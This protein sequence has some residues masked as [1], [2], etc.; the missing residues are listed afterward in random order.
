MP[1]RS[2]QPGDEHAQ[3]RI[4]NTVAGC[5]PAFKPSTAD[6]IARRYQPGD[7]DGASRY[8][9][10]EDGEIVGY[11][12]F[13]SN[14]RISYPWCLPGAEAQREPLLDTVLAEMRQRGLHQAWAAYRGDWTN[15]V[16][17][18]RAHGFRDK[19]T[20]INYIAEGSR[21][22]APVDL[23]PNRSITPLRP[24]D[25]P[26]LIAL[27]PRL[28]GD[29]AA[30]ELERFYW[31][32]PFYPL[33]QSLV[34]MRDTQSGAMVG[35]YLLV[36]SDRF[37]DPTKIDAAMPCFR[38]GAF[39]TERERHKRVTGLF[40]CVF[41]DPADGD[42]LLGAALRSRAPQPA[43]THIAAQAPSGAV[44]LCAWYDLRFQ[45]QGSFPVLSRD[46]SGEH[47]SHR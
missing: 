44:A 36:V 11:A 22:P 30:T 32:N 33:P 26:Q 5:L 15:V 1:I 31:H 12:V 47:A 35:A 37:A 16:D 40:S 42:L 41:T 45:R 13:G 7:P 21:L 25:L 8:Y 3:A 17:F 39:G 10:V 29:L 27:D 46:L 24:D 38:L 9:V 2:Y 14:G 23:P 28:F 34:A 18:L 43:L 20:M 4:Y 6:E 19:Q